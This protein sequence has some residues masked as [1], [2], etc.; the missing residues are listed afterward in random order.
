MQTFYLSKKNGRYFII[1][2]LAVTVLIVTAKLALPQTTAVSAEPYYQGDITENKVSLAINVDWG[3]EYIPDMLAVLDEYH[4][5][6]TFFLTGRWADKNPDIAAAIVAAG[7]EIGNHAYS[8]SSPNTNTYEQNIEEITKTEDAIAK[9]TGV[10]TRLYAPPSG[11][12]EEHVL[13]AAKDCGY[14]VILWSIDTIDWQKPDANTIVNRVVSKL[15]GGAIILAH[16]TA[17]TLAALPEII[18][19]AQEQGYVFTTVSKNIGL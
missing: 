9:A 1:Y 5:N 15:H 7:H 16:P 6:A 2:L 10:T 4:V 14:K 11:E 18:E 12:K 3:E 8:H 19:K 17:S 13:R